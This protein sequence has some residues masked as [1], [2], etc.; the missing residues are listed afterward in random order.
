MTRTALVLAAGLLAAAGRARAQETG[1]FAVLRGAD[2]IAVEQWAREDVSLEGTLVRGAGA[3]AARE[4]LRYHA[5]LVDDGSAPLLQL[6]AWRADDPD[7]H[8]ARQMVRLIFK[9]DSVA[10]DDMRT[11]A[12]VMTRVL[13][14]ARAAIPYLNLSVALLEQATRRAAREHADSLAV[15]FFNLGGGQTVIGALVRAGADSTA[16]RLGGV[17][18][19]L[20]VDGTGRI[21]GG[22][23]PAQGLLILRTAAR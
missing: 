8:R 17:E 19:R 4:R 12:G 18:F 9:D 2:T 14:T 11:G 22:A 7:D 23:V 5:T 13:P 6:S 21:L 10:V 1:G 3:P 15:P 20:R 16:L